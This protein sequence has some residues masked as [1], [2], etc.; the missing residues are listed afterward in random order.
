MKAF[1]NAKIKLLLPLTAQERAYTILYM[2]YSAEQ[3]DG[4]YRE[5]RNARKR[6]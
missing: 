5:G 1:I 2:G 6:L 3:L 4:Y